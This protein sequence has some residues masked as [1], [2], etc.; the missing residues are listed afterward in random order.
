MARILLVEDDKNVS[1]LYETELQA[2]GHDVVVVRDADAAIAAAGRQRP[3]LV[4]VDIRLEKQT[5]GI[6]LMSKLLSDD[7]GLPVIINTGYS[8]YKDSFMAWAAEAYIL[9]SADVG[10]LKQAVSDVLHKAA[11]PG[12]DLAPGA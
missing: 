5:D 7:V 9:K 8:Q 10:P 12:A 6:E 2:E 4:I 11:R 3:D 1:L